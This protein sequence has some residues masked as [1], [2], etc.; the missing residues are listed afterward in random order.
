MEHT[1]QY[2]TR[3]RRIG[4][5]A[6]ILLAGAVGGLAPGSGAVLVTSYEYDTGPLRVDNNGSAIEVRNVSGVP[7]Q[8]FADAIL[9]DGTA[10]PY[11]DSGKT[12]APNAVY[13][14][15]RL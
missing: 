4:V 11:Q 5:A 1:Q 14:T 9:G 7:T 13:S 8:I 6:A 3:L 10:L 2:R 12:F 15:F